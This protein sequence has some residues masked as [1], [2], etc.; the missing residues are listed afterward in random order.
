MYDLDLVFK[1]FEADSYGEILNNDFILRR[2][3]ELPTASRVILAWASLL[4]NAFSFSLVQKLTSGEFDAVDSDNSP[5]EPASA[6]RLGTLSSPKLDTVA[7]LH[8]ALQACILIPGD[9]ED[10]FR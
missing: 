7:G 6:A 9:D 10:Q 8:A 3:N 1:E 4:G 5:Q 2:L